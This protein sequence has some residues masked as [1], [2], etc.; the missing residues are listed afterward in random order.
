MSV[1]L[2]NLGFALVTLTGARYVSTLMERSIGISVELA[3]MSRWVGAVK[4]FE[5]ELVELAK[6]GL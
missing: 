4:M 1:T 3:E 5:I 6:G 2:P